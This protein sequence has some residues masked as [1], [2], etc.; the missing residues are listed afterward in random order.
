MLDRSAFT[1][2]LDNEMIS[3]LFKYKVIGTRILIY[4]YIKLHAS[5]LETL[6]VN[7]LGTKRVLIKETLGNLVLNGVP[8]S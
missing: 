7:S 3:L 8:E 1:V 5:Y 4:G 2:T 6:Y